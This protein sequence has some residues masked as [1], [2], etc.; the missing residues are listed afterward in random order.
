MLVTAMPGQAVQIV[1]PDPA[2]GGRGA[3]G[4]VAGQPSAVDVATPTRR[5]VEVLKPPQRFCETFPNGRDEF[6]VS[7]EIKI[8]QVALR[9]T[10]DT[11]PNFRRCCLYHLPSPPQVQGYK[12]EMAAP[13]CTTLYPVP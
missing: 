3:A 5:A 6:I 2:H 12:L 8:F 13:P 4:R 10:P 1:L 7:L 11:W 9:K